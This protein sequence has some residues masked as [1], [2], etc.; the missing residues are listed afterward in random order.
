MMNI[1][2]SLERSTEICRLGSVMSK[3]THYTGSAGIWRILSGKLTNCRL[4]ISLLNRFQLLWTVFFS[5]KVFLKTPW[6]P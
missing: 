4:S 1:E 5:W 2:P 6:K 3:S